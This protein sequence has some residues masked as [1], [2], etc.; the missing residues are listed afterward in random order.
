VRNLVLVD[1]GTPLPVPEHADIDDALHATLGPA[2]ERLGKV[3]PDRSSYFAMWSSHP[4]FADGI[5]IDLERNLLADLTEAPD[6]FRTAVNAAAVGH[7]GRELLADVGVRTLLELH[8][9]PIQIIRA[10]NGL[11]GA[12]PPLISDE[13]IERFGHHHWIRA[14]GTN[15]YTVLMGSSGASVVAAAIRTALRS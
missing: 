10:P 3:W 7:D 6:G 8:T 11:T 2:L 4:A 13:M 5:S 15:H 9:D 14:E 1:G 12:P